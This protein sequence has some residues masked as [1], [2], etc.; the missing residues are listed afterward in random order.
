MARRVGLRHEAAERM[1]PHDRPLDAER[2]AQALHVV[3]PLRER[4]GALVVAAAAPVAAVVVVDH[5]RDVGE[6]REGRLEQRM[7]EAR[8]AMQQHQSR[9]LA[10]SRAV[11]HQT[12]TLDIEI[13]P[14][15]IDLDEH[16]QPLVEAV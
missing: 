2:I 16:A 7:V 6:T 4:P 11:G 12:R 1:P 10:Q 13:E 3:A 9:L 14:D 5:L 15:A 8:S